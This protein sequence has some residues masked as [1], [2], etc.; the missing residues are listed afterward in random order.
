M[1]IKRDDIDK[2]F[3]YG[4]DVSTR[5]IYI[6]E[7]DG[8]GVD[9]PLAEKVIKSLHILD[10][11]APAG[12]NPIQIILNNPGGDEFHGIA[13]YDAIKNCKNY[14]GIRVYGQA[15]SMASII[16]QAADVGGREISENSIVMIHHGTWAMDDHY[17]N[18]KKWT[19][20]AEDVLEPWMINLYLKRIKEK[21]P[22][23]TYAKVDRMCDFDAILTAQEAVDL[24]LADKVI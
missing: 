23:M 16:L 2:F 18:V 20:Y 11:S 9:G 5:T 14:V 21:K 6:G 10:K 7:V 8:G 15:S 13:I 1:R 22:R 4:L 12:D 19:K 24:G 3:D 17:K